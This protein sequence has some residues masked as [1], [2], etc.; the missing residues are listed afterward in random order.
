[1]IGLLALS[2]AIAAVVYACTRRLRTGPRRLLAFL[3]FV[4]PPAAMAG[5]LTIVGDPAPP[6]P[7]LQPGDVYP[8][9]DP[10]PAR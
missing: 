6:G 3:V 7:D 1:M 9:R 4:I 2:A 10:E 5:F 8:G